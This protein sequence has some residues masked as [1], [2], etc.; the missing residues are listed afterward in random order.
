M[1]LSNY[2]TD[3]LF[4]LMGENPLPNAVAALTLLK[5]GGTPILIHTERTAAQAQYLTQ[6]LKDFSSLQPA[7]C[8]DLGK[9]QADASAIQQTIG[10]IAQSLAGRIGMNYTGGTK[11]M[12]VHAYRAVESVQPRAVFSYLDSNTLEMTLEQA[13]QASLRVKVSPNL[14]LNQL[15]RLHGLSWQDD[16]PPLNAPMLPEAAGAIAHFHQSPDLAQA[17][18]NWCNRQLRSVAKN[19]YSRWRSEAE[20]AG[21]DPIDLTGLPEVMIAKVMKPY[22]GGRDG[23]LPLQTAQQQGF[24]DLTQVCE[25]LDGTWLEHHVLFQI[26]Q[27]AS[28]IGIHDS[29][30]SFNIRDPQ[31]PHQSWAKFEFD[32]AFMHHYQL[33]ALSCTTTDKRSLCKQKL[34]EASV[35]AR[36]LGGAEARV[37]LVCCHHNPN[38]LRSE[39][40]V[41]TRNQKIAVFGRLDLMN[42]GGCIAK[43][44]KQNG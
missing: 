27:V 4:L 41:A 26:Q 25:W 43:W 35:R 28:D 33:F 20:L 15:F 13:G 23:F 16:R 37:G 22:L 17:W 2:Q 38:S 14:S 10:K 7:R 32:V 19:E 6:V 31:K 3:Y 1:N 36:Q 5:S 42:L 29:R 39:L 40:E 11:V 18:R 21:L 34:M 12:S 9:G 30:V 24:R 8:V 44:V